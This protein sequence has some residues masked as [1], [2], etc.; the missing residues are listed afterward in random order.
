MKRMSASLAACAFAGALA[1]SP[2]ATLAWGSTGH[3]MINRIAAEKLPASLPAFLH[4]QQ[5]IDE[6][7]YLG[8]EEDRLKGAGISWDGDNDEGHYLDLQ[9][10]GTI[11]HVISI[12]ALPKDM[13]AYADAL[14]KTNTTPY[15]QGFLPYTIM[16]GFEQTR[17]DFA[18]WR[19]DDY[20]ATH[21]T[22]DAVKT[23]YAA[24]RAL[25]ESLIVRD[26]G[27]WGHFVGDGSQ[28]LHVT[29]HFNGWG[30][31]PNPKN[32]STS[33]HVHAMFESDFVTA[34]VKAG[35]VTKDVAAY[36]LAAP[37]DLVSQA[38]LA[39]MVGTYL[40]GSASAVTHLYDI[41]AAHGFSNA[42]PDAVSFT[43]Q[44]LARGA[45]ELRDLITYAWEDSVNEN[46]GYPEVKVR[47]ILNGSHPFDEDAA[48]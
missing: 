32:Y 46:V 7:A 48:F 11:A 37:S 15:K 36:A 27:V 16:D 9:D 20:I 28:P 42:T 13:A 38:A 43:A 29:V 33:H 45:S 8:P 21:A 39:S 40:S 4:T 2:V 30:D 6:I 17:K 1:A 22:T 26:I 12:T 14:S 35:D 18:Y 31:F 3:T 23:R 44:Q 5:A 34:H 47:D 24:A 19:V 25:R 10:D 41:E